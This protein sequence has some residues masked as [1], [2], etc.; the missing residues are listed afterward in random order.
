[1]SPS[2][3]EPTT[4]KGVV[5]A[6]LTRADQVD[7][8]FDV[9]FWSAVGA[10]GRFAAAWQ[11]VEEAQLIRGRSGGQPRLQRSVSVLERR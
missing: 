10:V 4:R 8:S 11:M 9:E 5:M 1:M 2:P 6:R 7:R 3:E